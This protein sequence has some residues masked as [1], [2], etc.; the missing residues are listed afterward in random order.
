VEI[1]EGVFKTVGAVIEPKA[2]VFVHWLATKPH[3]EQA[4]VVVIQLLAV[5]QALL[6]FQ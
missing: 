6:V 5:P 2:L 4:I 1:V 3:D